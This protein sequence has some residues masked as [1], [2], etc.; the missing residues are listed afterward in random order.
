VEK[1]EKGEKKKIRKRKEKGKNWGSM[2][3]IK[4]TNLIPN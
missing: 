4:K 3:L 1:L 2:T